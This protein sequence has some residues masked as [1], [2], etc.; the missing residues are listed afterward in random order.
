M[1]KLK[2]SPDFVSEIWSPYLML[3]THALQ[4]IWRWWKISL[5][6]ESTKPG[7]LRESHPDYLEDSLL[8][9]NV[10]PFVSNL[11]LVL[12]HSFIRI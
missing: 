5:R 10:K 4:V 7:E 9:S 8:Q 1:S 2:M 6:S 11:N 3:T 12:P